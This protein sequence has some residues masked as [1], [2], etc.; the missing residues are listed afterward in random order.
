LGG[1][2]YA[3]SSCVFGD[4]ARLTLAADHFR[5]GAWGRGP[6]I[7]AGGV[8][9]VEARHCFQRRKKRQKTY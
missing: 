2:T 7:G 1:E 4:L 8:H 9:W 6:K 5:L 3:S